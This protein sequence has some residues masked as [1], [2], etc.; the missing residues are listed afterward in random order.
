[1]KDDDI[2]LQCG[3][4]VNTGQHGRDITPRRLHS[5]RVNAQAIP[6]RPTGAP[7]RSSSYLLPGRRNDCRFA[8]LTHIRVIASPR[9]RAVWTA[10]DCFDGSVRLTL[11]AAGGLIGQFP[12]QNSPKHE[13]AES[14]HGSTLNADDVTAAIN[15]LDRV[16]F[17]RASLARM[18]TWPP[19]MTPITA[20]R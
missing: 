13:V 16:A 5:A 10:G 14:N 7:C 4:P 2:F 19:P 20:P 17:E 12:L 15:G 18:G 3:P 1:M 11:G 9:Y 6:V 8:S